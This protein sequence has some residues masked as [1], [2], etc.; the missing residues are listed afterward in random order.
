[1]KK[2][3]AFGEKIMEITPYSNNMI[4]VRC[5]SAGS[6]SLFDRY[7]LLAKPEENF[8]ED[9]ENG[10]RAGDLSVTYE[11][12]VITLKTDRVERGN[13]YDIRMGDYVVADM[14]W[15]LIGNVVIYR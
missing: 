6:E 11:N 9:I 14:S 5:A 10:V 15:Y 3:F 7:N 12:G 4:R 8:G 13:I 2:E 1:M